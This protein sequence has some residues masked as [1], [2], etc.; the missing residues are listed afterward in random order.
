MVFDSDL[1]MQVLAVDEMTAY[2]RLAQLLQR[3]NGKHGISLLTA[4]F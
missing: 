3:F 2:I 4:A 1:R